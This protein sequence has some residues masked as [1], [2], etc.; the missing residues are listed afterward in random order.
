MTPPMVFFDGVCNLCNGTVNFLIDHDPRR[1][2]RYAP[3]QGRTFA[4]LR[5]SH[6]DLP[7]LGSI[8]L[9]DEKGLHFKS[10]AV[11]RTLRVLGGVWRVAVVLLVIPRPLRDLAYDWVAKHRYR[12]FGKADSCRTP[13]PELRDRFLE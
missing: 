7:E 4:E 8:V 12:W 2:L 9:L 11:L 5:A 10:R 1:R 6:P 13:T 3:L